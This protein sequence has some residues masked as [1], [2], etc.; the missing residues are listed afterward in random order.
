LRC[1][2]DSRSIIAAYSVPFT[3]WSISS[4]WDIHDTN[5]CGVGWKLSSICNRI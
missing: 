3:L 2:G 4:G 1:G 5:S